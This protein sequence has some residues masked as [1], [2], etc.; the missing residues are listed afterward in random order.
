MTK[1][2]LTAGLGL[3]AGVAITIAAQSFLTPSPAGTDEQAEADARGPHGGRLLEG[4]VLTLEVTIFEEG[5]P[6]RYRIFPMTT[7]GA[8]LDPTDVQL[9]AVLERLGG[10]TAQLTFT[11]EG[12]YLR[13]NEVV[14]EP[15]SFVATFA[16]RSHGRSDTL[17]YEQVEGRTEIAEAALA[18][19]GISV[20]TAAGGDLT[21][22]IDLPGEVVLS[23][24][25]HVI[26]SARA[27]GVLTEVRTSVGQ[28]VER[29][30]VLAVI[31]SPQVATAASAYAAARARLEFARTR[32]DREA[33]LVER[34]ITALQ[35]LQLAEQAFA[36]AAAEVNDARAVLL[37]FGLDADAIAALASSPAAASHLPVTAPARGVITSQSAGQGE[38]VAGG[39][40]LLTV[41][42]ASEVWVNV[43]VHARDLDV[44]GRGRRVV[45]RGIGTNHE[46]TG[47]ITTV[48]PLVGEDT[49][50]ATARVALSNRDGRWHPGLFVTVQVALDPAPAAVVVP[51]DA[52]QT[53][54]DWSVVFVRYGN[55]FEARPVEPG[56]TDGRVVE[57]V[58]GL[59]PGERYAA[60]NA[61]VVK[62]DILKD[63]ASHDH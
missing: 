25:R 45:V 36:V 41:T 17:Q 56:R 59:R 57:I 34:R 11:P 5:V 52:V 43:Q 62:A 48:S 42:D 50:T 49:R 12:A 38:S 22:T 58:T 51:V 61:Y 63:G 47:T 46:A 37:G 24:D 53:F 4:N 32:R 20:A 16:A 29:G 60:T 23:P 28:T 54:R 33:T 31:T 21:P 18:S 19:T 35:D 10:T 15:H 1:R 30:D 44:V 26:V 13:S 9:T 14:E 2:W 3:A 7:D 40:P 27:P 39:A 8:P 6:P 55:V